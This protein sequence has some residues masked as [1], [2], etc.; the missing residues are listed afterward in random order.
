MSSRVCRGSQ[1]GEDVS[2][3]MVG[4]HIQHVIVWEDIY[5]KHNKYNKCKKK[6]K[7][8][9]TVSRVA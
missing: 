1:E 6:I 5:N 9:N 4:Q 8:N 3:Q 7:K 2:V